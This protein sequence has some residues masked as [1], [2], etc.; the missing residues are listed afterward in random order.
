MQVEEAQLCGVILDPTAV[1]GQTA[2]VQGTIILIGPAPD[3]GTSIALES[4]NPDVAKVEP[5]VE[6]P[7]GSNNA[8][9]EVS[10]APVDSPT[11]VTITASSQDVKRTATLTVQPPSLAQ[12][13]LNPAVV[14]GGSAAQG[15]VTLNG[16][17]PANFVVALQSTDATVATV[18]A[19]IV[20]PQNAASG[21]F[22]VTTRPVPTARQVVIVASRAGVVRSATLTVQ[23][24]AL[25]SFTFSPQQIGGGETSLGA[26]AL[27]GPAPAGT[28][29]ALSRSNAV[30]ADF[31]ATVTV[32]AGATKITFTATGRV[33]IGV[34][35]SVTVT[36]TYLGTARTAT[37]TVFGEPKD[38]EA[39][40]VLVKEK[41]DE[42]LISRTPEAWQPVAA[43]E[44][45]GGA[46][47]RDPGRAF[48]RPAER[49]AP[50]RRVL[51]Q[52]P[53]QE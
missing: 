6:V 16:P 53:E 41:E 12:L 49:A 17:A 13:T 45:A 31:P 34:N 42:F 7:A 11:A 50:G 3:D 40:K 51:D 44:E 21:A 8:A 39:E 38:K 27:S 36:A 5:S 35:R 9:F 22:P 43:D 15:T 1:I 18:P 37:L 4:D 10:T 48:V 14:L 25:V 30:T 47:E 46:E 2:T 26:I 19:E 23:S 29:V 33:F 32:P 28:S 52:P 24:L 20:I